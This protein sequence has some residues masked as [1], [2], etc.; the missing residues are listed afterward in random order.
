[1][2]R[3]A[4]SLF[5]CAFIAILVAGCTAPTVAPP[6]TTAPPTTPAT[7]I[8]TTAPVTDPA[9]AGRWYLKAVTGP[10][11]STPFQTIGVQITAIFTEQ[12][13]LSG[14]GGCNDYDAQY[15]LTGEVLPNGKG[16]TIGPIVSTEKYCQ[17]LSTTEAS[18]LQILQ[19]VTSYTVNTNQQLSLT[20]N[21]GRI[22]L[23]SPTPYGVTAV[24]IGS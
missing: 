10:G 24:P 23:F 21:S 6:A 22:L 9:L 7:P 16:I 13:D 2:K 8:P 15:V 11:G 17:D 14:F 5:I 20:D 12:G 1:M 18:Y 3:M 19:N 4:I